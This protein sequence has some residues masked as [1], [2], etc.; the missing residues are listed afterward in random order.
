MNGSVYLIEP[1]NSGDKPVAARKRNNVVEIVFSYI[2]D[3]S[4]CV[5]DTNEE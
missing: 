5:N 3:T 4:A 1:M 2:V